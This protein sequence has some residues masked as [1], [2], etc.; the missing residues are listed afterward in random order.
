MDIDEQLGWLDGVIKLKVKTNSLQGIYF[1]VAGDQVV[2]V[3]KTNSQGLGRAFSHSD[4]EFSAVFFWP[5]QVDRRCIEEIERWLIRVFMPKYNKTEKGMGV[6]L[7]EAKTRIEETCQWY[8]EPPNLL[9][10]PGGVDEDVATRALITGDY[11]AAFEKLKAVAEYIAYEKMEQTT[12]AILYEI[13][14]LVF[15]KREELMLARSAEETEAYVKLKAEKLAEWFSD[16]S[17][18]IKVYE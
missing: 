8:S 17:K 10:I 5:L 11:E 1:L 16:Y 9:N 14:K 18:R 3:G 13:A 7:R 12:E 4:K 15:N 2:Y 6:S